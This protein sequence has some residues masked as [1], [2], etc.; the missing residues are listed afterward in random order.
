M[1]SIKQTKL[2]VSLQKTQETQETQETQG[3]KNNKNHGVS[4]IF[5]K[6]LQTNK[7]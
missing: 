2:G 7:T 1:T 6:N 3:F 4:F 5:Q